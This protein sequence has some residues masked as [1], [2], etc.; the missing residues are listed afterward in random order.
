MRTWAPPS[1]LERSDSAAAHR[2]GASRILSH[3]KAGLPILLFVATPMR[4]CGAEEQAKAYVQAS[5][6]LSRRDDHH[7]RGG[8]RLGTRGHHARKTWRVVAHDELRAVPCHRPHR[9]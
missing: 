9:R 7:E 2:A 8:A 6:L 3:I 1:H 5:F 4:P